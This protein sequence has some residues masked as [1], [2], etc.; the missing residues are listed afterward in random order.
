VDTGLF[1]GIAHEVLVAHP[2][3]SVESVRLPS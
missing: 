1:V 3:G 2:D